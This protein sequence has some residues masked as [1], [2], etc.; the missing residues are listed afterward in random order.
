LDDLNKRIATINR[1]IGQMIQAQQRE[2]A[3]R[4]AKVLITIRAEMAKQYEQFEQDGK[5]SLQQMLKYDRLKK[6]NQ[7]MEHILN[8]HY[9]DF[10]AALYKAMGETYKEGY[11]LTGHAVEMHIQKKI[12]Y[13]AVRPETFKAMLDNPINGLTLNQR[14]Q[15]RRAYIIQQIQKQITLGLQANESYA[16][17][18]K[19]LKGELEGDTVKAMRIVRT[20][21][22]RVQ[23]SAKFDAMEFADQNGVVMMKQWNTLEDERVRRRPQDK[24]DHKKLNNKKIPMD[25]MFNDGLSAGPA[26]GQLPAA[27]SS[28]NCRCFLTYSVERLEKKS[29]KDIERITFGQWKKENVK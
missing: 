11:Y 22:H 12:G 1:R 23:E 21:G 25:Q 18:A 4:Y 27:A 15:K 6:L 17:M 24:A 2:T 9:K 7:R 3:K 13:R 19:R 16:S 28:I 8:A 26:P 5:L 10:A 14:L 20:E 29:L